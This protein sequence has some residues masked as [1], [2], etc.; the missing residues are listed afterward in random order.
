MYQFKTEPFE[1]QLTRFH[2]YKDEPVWGHLWEQGTGK[3]KEIIDQ[4]AYNYL[5]GR[6]NGLMI[7][8]PGGVN[9]NWVTDEIP[10]HLPDR[11]RGC[12]TTLVWDSFKASTQKFQ[13]LVQRNLEFEGFPILVFTY[14]NFMTLKGKKGAWNFMKN[15]DIMA[16]LDESHYVKTPKA[17]RTKSIVASGRYPKMKRILTGT[18][19]SVGP[20][21]I[22]SQMKYLDEKFW[23]E[24]GC[25]NFESFKTMFG[26]FEDCVV[27]QNGK[28]VQFRKL[29][30]YKNLELL[31]DM[32]AR[33]TDRVLKEDVLDLPPKIYTKRYFHASKEQ[34]KLYEELAEFMYVQLTQSEA[35]V[36]KI[37]L[38]L[39]LRFQQLLSGYIPIMDLETEDQRLYPLKENPRLEA[40]I[41][42]IEGQSD[43]GMVWSNFTE[44]TDQIM[45]R[46]EK[47]GYTAVRY[48]GT[49]SK[50]EAEHNRQEFKAS[51]VQWFVGSPKKGREG[52]TFINAKTVDYYTNSFRL[53]DRL[54]TEDRPHR[55][56][57]KD[58]VLY[59]D[60]IALNPFNNA[61]L[62]DQRFVDNLRNKVDIASAI[63]GDK[64]K[65][66]I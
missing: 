60:Y 53:L 58:T 11:V 49:I 14:D 2:K 51:K 6:I 63:T 9:L 21:D 3:T 31:K 64:L 1:H 59:R 62:V 5:E 52:L 15:R 41:E 30:E 38:V 17:K 35:A 65:E 40:F 10:T 43:C 13:K 12:S 24:I 61:P 50:E 42:N 29:I 37:K 66:W 27:K 8:A 56:G 28:E 18:P 26:T 48:D 23:D 57:Q 34:M 16:V 7:V 45:A 33:K 44:D 39:L 55:A 20:F 32:V 4:A 47:E 25:R 54:Q 46:L 22:F 19:I 36:A